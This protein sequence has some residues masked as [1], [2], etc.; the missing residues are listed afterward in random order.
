MTILPSAVI[1]TSCHWCQ[2][3]G[4]RNSQWCWNRGFNTILG[5]KLL[6]LLLA[7]YSFFFSYYY[8]HAKILELFS[9]F[10]NKAQKMIQM[11]SRWMLRFWFFFILK[12][13]KDDVSK[14]EKITMSFAPPVQW[15]R[16]YIKRFVG[17]SYSLFV[18]FTQLNIILEYFG[19]LVIVCIVA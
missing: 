11:A 16:N 10:L 18:C 3:L 17:G 14:K 19:F 13:H 9:F 15:N 7:K 1:S 5:I 12:R 2:G 4:E 8:F 6:T